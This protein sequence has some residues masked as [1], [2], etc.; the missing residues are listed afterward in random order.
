MIHVGHYA[1]L[2]KTNILSELDH[3]A[4]GLQFL[5]VKHRSLFLLLIL[6]SLAAAQTRKLS[7]KDLPPSAF[8]LISVKVSGNQRYTPQEI[9]EIAGLK[10]GQT[11]SDADFKAATQHLG[12]TGAFS[13]V[14]YSYQ[15]ASDGTKLTFQVTEADKLVPAR[16]DNIV[17]FT[18]QELIAKLHE[19]VPLFHGE[20]PVAGNLP[21]QV[22]DA[23]Q[24]LLDE[25]NLQARVDYLRAA[26]ADGPIDAIVYSV[27][28]TDIRIRNIDFAGAA[29]EELQLLQAAAK[30]MQ[31]SDYLRSIL[32]VQ[33][34]KNLLPVYLARGYLKASFGDA[35]PKVVEESPKQTLVDVIFPASPGL[36]YKVSEV[37]L[38]G[39]NA[40][41]AARLQSMLHLPIGQPANA[42]QLNDDL[43]A[44]RKLYGTK[45]YMAA[46]LHPVP[47]MDDQQSTVR[48]QIEIKEGSVYKMGELNIEGLDKQTTARLQEAWQLRGGDPYDSSYPPRFLEETSREIEGMGGWRISI[49]E[50][51]DDKD[52]VVDVTIR[53]DPKPR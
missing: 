47:Q 24:A 53:Y 20:L 43:G 11:V 18:D 40:F 25:R 51:L 36:Q 46:S 33:E 39:Q 16:F 19:R 9:T 15:F 5:L 31:G 2:Q 12:D 14:A 7:P 50:A 28:S 8:K 48:Y 3:S 38:S 49:R 41:P 52:E 37:K 23:L 29:P 10:L 32:R 35:Q 1:D 6:A 30:P 22:S 17:W 34:D 26:K 4:T 42:V 13:D 44:I 45:G 21:D 27:K